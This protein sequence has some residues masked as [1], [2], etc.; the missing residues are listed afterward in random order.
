MKAAPWHIDLVM[1]ARPNFMK[2]APLYHE[3]SR[4]PSRFALRLVHTG[5]HYDALMSDVF[6][7]ELGLPTPHVHLGA[8][9]GTQAE[10]TA[11]VLTSYE[12]VLLAERPDWVVVVGDVNST[13]ACALA[14]AKLA[15]PV[16]VAH[17]EAGLRSGD[18]S[19]PEEINRLVTDSLADLLLTPSPDADANLR[20]EGVAARQIHRV[21]NIMIDSLKRLAPRAAR[22]DVRA[23]LGLEKPYVL[24]TLHRPSNVDDP[25]TL[26]GI[27]H[28]LERLAERVPVVFPAHPRTQARLRDSV[29]SGGTARDRL[30]LIDPLG[31]VDFLRLQRDARLV[32]TDSGGVQEETTVLGVPCLTLRPNT[33]RGITLTRGTN[34]LVGSRPEA[35]LRAAFAALERP[36]RRRPPIPLWDGRT[37]QRIASVFAEL[38]RS[39]TT[40]SR[41]SAPRARGRRPVP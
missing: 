12:A 20:R 37:A 36:P 18:R 32:L 16:R 3:L 11:R 17:V 6:L 33:E 2:I 30:R 1:G 19:M 13:L 34:R 22:S 39:A 25:G 41:R 26:E 31:Y 14:A 28:A 24:V 4:Q 38:W 35:I 7:Q 15:P 21:G 10:Q 27:V 9:S 5:Q 40:A 23:Q 8:G 29:G